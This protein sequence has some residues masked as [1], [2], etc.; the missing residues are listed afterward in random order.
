MLHLTLQLQVGLSNG[1]SVLELELSILSP[2]P[3]FVT[4]QLL[5]HDV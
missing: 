3:W 4:S 1:F 5:R 2:F